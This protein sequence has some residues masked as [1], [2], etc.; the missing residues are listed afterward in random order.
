MRV[1]LIGYGPIRQC[2]VLLLDELGLE[3]SVISP[4]DANHPFA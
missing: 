4:R 1:I 3:T 2:H